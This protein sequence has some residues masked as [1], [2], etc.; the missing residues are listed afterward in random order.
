[1]G[2]KRIAPYFAKATVDR[3]CSS[4]GADTNSTNSH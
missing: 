4:E 3:E 2:L 1:M